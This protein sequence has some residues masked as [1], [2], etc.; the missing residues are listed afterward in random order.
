LICHGAIA[1]DHF[2]AF[3]QENN[4]PS[5]ED[6]FRFEGIIGYQCVTM[7]ITH[8]CPGIFI[9]LEKGIFQFTVYIVAKY[10]KLHTYQV[11]VIGELVTKR[12]GLRI[13][14]LLQVLVV[15]GGIIAC[16]AG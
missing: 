13:G 12:V 2:I 11:L 9:F 16:Q 8:Q 1:L 3:P 7:E 15:L 4:L 5:A 14:F 6:T 10:K